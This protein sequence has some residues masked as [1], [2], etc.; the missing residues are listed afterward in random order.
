MIYCLHEIE[1]ENE[2]MNADLNRAI[3]LLSEGHYTCVACKGEL[4]HTATF[5]GVKPLVRW[6]DDQTDLTGFSAADK[7]VGKATAYLYCLLGVRAVHAYVMSTAAMEVLRNHGIDA[8]CD[9]EVP[10]I[11]NRAG[12]GPCP[13]EAAV[14]EIQ[15]AHDALTAIRN[16]RRQMLEGR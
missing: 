6:L 7:V 3:A 1:M 8:R 2:F 12:D 10:G 11:I 14:L 13:F 5:R 9:K 15:D 4:L 16:K